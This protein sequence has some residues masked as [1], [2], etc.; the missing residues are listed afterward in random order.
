MY[1]ML[2]PGRTGNKLRRLGS[3]SSFIFSFQSSLNACWY[4]RFRWRPI[5]LNFANSLQQ[6]LIEQDPV[7]PWHL[8]IILM[9]FVTACKGHKNTM[10]WVINLNFKLNNTYVYSIWKKN[11]KLTI[12]L[13]IVS[14]WN[15]KW[16]YLLKALKR[17]QKTGIFKN[18]MAW[19][20]LVNYIKPRTYTCFA[21][22]VIFNTWYRM[23]S[24]VRTS[25]GFRS[26][27]QYLSARHIVV[28]VHGRR[29]VPS[30]YEGVQK[31]LGRLFSHPHVITTPTPV[32][33][34]PAWNVKF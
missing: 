8:H 10:S 16:H 1:T 27:L 6:V 17:L 9:V 15:Q 32:P 31:F 29:S 11:Q 7:M 20:T 33:V 26:C 22:S 13:S 28:K 2:L 18:N 25:G 14:R 24:D 34:K 3:F 21:R 19:N 12:H 23:N 4:L 30:C 5:F